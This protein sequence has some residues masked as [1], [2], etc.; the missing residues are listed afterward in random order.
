MTRVNS[1][2]LSNYI[3]LVKETNKFTSD[4]ALFGAQMGLFSEVGSLVSLLK[5]KLLNNDSNDHSNELVV[6]EMGDIFWY[7]TLITIVKNIDLYEL[8]NDT[9]PYDRDG[10]TIVISGIR[11]QPFV[12][13]KS[14]TN[15]KDTESLFSELISHTTSLSKKATV[16]KAKDFLNIYSKVMSFLN[17]DLLNIVEHNTFKIRNRFVPIDELNLPL[18]SFDSNF[19]KDE[20]LPVEFEVYIIE[21]PNGKAYLKWND[22]FIGSALNDNHQEDDNYKYHDVFH[23][24]FAAILHWSPTFRA[25]IKHKRKSD[26]SID[27][28]Q[29]SGRPIVIEE[30]LSAWLFSISKQR[31][32]DFTKESSISY[33]L[34]KTIQIFVRGYEVESCPLQLWVKA[35]IQGYKV[36]NQV[37]DNKGGIIIGN[38]RERTLD[39]RKLND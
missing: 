39:F 28:T 8:T 31:D 11:N 4:K 9:D 19:S 36:F 14:N 32:I 22:V 5:K 27:E 25:L 33:D 24:A 3:E 17:L 23:L 16:E 34:L 21:K 29:D 37:V 6:E 18:L 26:P 38:R 30:G 7:F 10:S 20:Q 13:V 12:K 35:I 1:I 2:S 15:S